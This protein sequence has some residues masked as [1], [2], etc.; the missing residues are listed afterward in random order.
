[1][2]RNKHKNHN[3][4]INNNN[5]STNH[6]NQ[7]NKYKNKGNN[8]TTLIVCETIEINRVYVYISI[9]IPNAN[10]CIQFGPNFLFHLL[11]GMGLQILN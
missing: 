11:D 3:N 4:N 2:K 1:M 5:H 6:N 9:S 7:A 10:N 8:K